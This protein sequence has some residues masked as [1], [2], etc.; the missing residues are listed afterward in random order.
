MVFMTGMYDFNCM[1]NW[2]WETLVSLAGRLPIFTYQLFTKYFN[3]AHLPV[4]YPPIDTDYHLSMFYITSK[5]SVYA[6]MVFEY[7]FTKIYQYSF[8]H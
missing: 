6:C 7:L 5:F 4:F 1:E 2:E 3:A 8:C